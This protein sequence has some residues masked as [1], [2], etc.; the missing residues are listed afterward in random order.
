M[1]ATVLYQQP[2]TAHP[3]PSLS[4]YIASVLATL[5]AALV[6]RSYLLSLLC[7]GLQVSSTSMGCKKLRYTRLAM[8]DLPSSFTE[9]IMRLAQA[10]DYGSLVSAATATRS[11]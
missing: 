10:W 7:S 2:P 1:D 8:S 9:G 11:L 6:M 4:G 3:P 5:Y